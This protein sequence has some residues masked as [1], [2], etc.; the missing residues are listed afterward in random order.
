MQLTLMGNREMD[1]PDTRSHKK[2]NPKGIKKHSAVV[3]LYHKSITAL[4]LS[5]QAVLLSLSTARTCSFTA[6]IFHP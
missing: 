2:V 6:R 1:S 4:T 3:D 5:S